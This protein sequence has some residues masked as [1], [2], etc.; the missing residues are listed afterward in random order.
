MKRI[1]G[2]L[3]RIYASEAGRWIAAAVL[4]LALYLLAVVLQP[5]ITFYDNDDLNIAW[6]LAGYRSGLPSYAHPFINCITAFVVSALYGAFPSVP[7][8]YAVQTGCMLL[9][10]TCVT[11][12]T[13]K[14]AFRRRW[15]LLVPLMITALL[16]AGA[17][18]YAL[19]Q[20]MFTLSSTLLGMASAAMAL[21]AEGDDPPARR[22]FYWI[23]CVLLLGLSLLIRQS[24]GLCAACFVFGCMAFRLLEGGRDKG[25]VQRVLVAAVSAVLLLAALVGVNAWGR[26]N[27]N[28]AGFIEFENARAAYMDYPHDLQYENKPLYDAIGWDETLQG[29]VEAWFFMDERVNADTL[30]MA[31]DGATYANL[32][33]PMRAARAWESV[34]V[35]LGKYPIAVY[36]VIMI[37]CALAALL[38]AFLRYR[39]VLPLLGGLCMAAGGAALLAF[40][41][42]QGRM[43][44]RT[45]MTIAFPALMTIL[46]FFLLSKPETDERETRRGAWLYAACGGMALVSLFCGYKIFRTVVSY[47]SVDTLAETRAVAEYAMAHGDGVYIRD[48]YTANNFDA[49][50]VYPEEKPTNLIDWGGCDMYT[51]ARVAQ[52]ALN[53][54]DAPPNAQVFLDENV[55]YLCNPSEQYLPLFAAYMRERCGAAGYEITDT[56]TPNVAVVRFY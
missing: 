6:A 49:L 21:A 44:L 14:L 27:Q 34:G 40:L 9:A 37:A 43:N 50:T 10:V 16:C 1:V 45:H 55:Y 17:Y 19:S 13:L 48:V 42:W 29:L 24:S 7:W 28:P 38:V 54:Y 4:A 30:S 39:R 5:V 52:W 47:D 35:F 46:L 56:I 33:V 53:G 41:Y 51:R 12:A 22:R 25:R 31:A 2:A 32:P 11:A 18:Y 26:A 20:V 36:L 8:W 23:A 15:P 3:H